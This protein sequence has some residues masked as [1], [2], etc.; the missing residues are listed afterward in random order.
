VVLKP[1]QLRVLLVL[2][3]FASCSLLAAVPA[4]GLHPLG[5][6]ASLL[7]LQLAGLFWALLRS[8]A[9][10]SPRAAAA[11]QPAARMLPTSAEWVP[12]VGSDDG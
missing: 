5:V 2:A 12:A 1:P 8:P 4:D 11:P 9:S 10:L 6:L 3:A 7:P